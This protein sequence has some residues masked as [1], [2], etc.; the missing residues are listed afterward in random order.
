MW[1]PGWEEKFVEKE[2]MLL[3]VWLSPLVMHEAI[4]SYNI[5]NIKL[6]V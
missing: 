4:L 6:K 3:F 2:Y 5:F 1:Q